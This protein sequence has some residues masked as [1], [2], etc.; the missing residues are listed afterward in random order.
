MSNSDVEIHAGLDRRSVQLCDY[1]S[2]PQPRRRRCTVIEHSRYDHATIGLI[3][4]GGT[5]PAGG[6]LALNSWLNCRFDLRF[7]RLDF[8]D[9]SCASA[10]CR[11]RSGSRR[12][13]NQISAQEDSQKHS[14]DDV[15]K[16]GTQ[17]FPVPCGDQSYYVAL[18]F[19]DQTQHPPVRF[20]HGENLDTLRSII[21]FHWV[22]DCF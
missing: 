10:R 6:C 17:H 9:S 2:N 8:L 7:W 11:N 21:T 4:C 15:I 20:L 12:T 13:R 19:N 14:Y 22:D 5:Y 16:I 1:V 3:S 18:I